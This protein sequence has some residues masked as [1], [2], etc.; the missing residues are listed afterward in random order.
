MNQTK[1]KLLLVPLKKENIKGFRRIDK[2][3]GK[4]A[5]RRGVVIR[6]LLVPTGSKQN[7]QSKNVKMAH[8]TLHCIYFGN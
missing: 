8:Q 3:D 6:R 2:D 7:R 1:K 5:K 4:G